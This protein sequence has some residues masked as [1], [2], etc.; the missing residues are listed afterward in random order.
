MLT[1]FK[2]RQS[3]RLSLFAIEAKLKE[4]INFRADTAH[5]V[6]SLLFESSLLECLYALLYERE[7]N[8]VQNVLFLLYVICAFAGR[9]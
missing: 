2:Q 8:L 3:L 9:R 1:I 5:A 7:T 4:F 6:K